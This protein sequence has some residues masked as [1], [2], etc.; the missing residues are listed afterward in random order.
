MLAY[1]QLFILIKATPRRSDL[2]EAGQ[3]TRSILAWWESCSLGSD[4]E[5][6]LTSVL[7]VVEAYLTEDNLKN[8]YN[9]SKYER[10]HHGWIPVERVNQFNKLSTYKYETILNALCSKRSNIIELNFCEPIS[11][12]RRRHPLI[13]P[14]SQYNV[15]AHRTV[16]VHGLPRDASLEE[17]IIY[18]NRF[19]P[20]H[21]IKMLPSSRTHGTFSGKIH[22]IFE[23]D[24]DA[25]EFC[26]RAESATLIYVN[27][28]VL[29]LCNGYTLVCQM[30]LDCN[31]QDQTKLIEKTDRLQL[32]NGKETLDMKWPV[33]ERSV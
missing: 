6:W 23:V 14:S 16:V 5:R 19:Y 25:R 15:D 4:L 7:C 9:L 18:F 10:E 22:V 26:R 12:R 30:L 33:N 13:R 2:R 3:F 31:D 32:D 27:D 24:R 11:L 1:V 20:V 17:L 28:Y 21:R 8:D 29:Q